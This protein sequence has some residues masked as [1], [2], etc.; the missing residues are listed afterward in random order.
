MIRRHLIAALT[1]ASV[2]LSAGPANAQPRIGNAQMATQPAP[3]PLEQGVRSLVKAQAEPAWIG[4]AVP[5]VSGDRRM[6]CAGSGNTY[7]SGSVVIVDGQACCTPCNLEPSRGTAR[8]SAAAQPPSGPVKLEGTDRMIVLLRA[9]DGQVERIRVFSE[10]C[11]IDGGGRRVLWLEGVAP[12]DSIALLESLARE[13]GARDRVA[14]GAVSA[15]ALHADTAA[16]ASLER[17]VDPA[18]PE[19]LRRKVTFWLGNARGARGLALLERVLQRDPSVEVRKSAVFGI[20][21]SPEAGAFDR[22]AALARS[23]ASPRIRSEA[24]FW[25]AHREEARAAQ[26]ILEVLEKDAAPEVR[27]KT[28]FALSQ[29]RNDAGVEP[30]IRIARTHAEPATRGEAIFWLAQK[31]GARAAAQITEAIEQ[32]PDTEVKKRAVFA[33]SQFPRNEGVPMLIQVARTHQNPA[34]RKQAMFWLGQSKDPRAVEFFAEIL[35]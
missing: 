25:I 18:M 21:Q 32:D 35:K 7:I 16:D 24:V 22:L 23:D 5:V 20:S 10:D 27:K 29:L 28:V 12:A 17:L 6:C 33:L 30:L 19:P 8:T 3:R 31:A 2:V 34:V 15:I 1:I 11:E 9:A 26:V 13:T 14:D 4:Y